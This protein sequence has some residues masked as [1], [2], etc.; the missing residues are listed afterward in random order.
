MTYLSRRI[1]L[2][3]KVVLITGASSGIGA[4]CAKYFAAEQANL[5]LCARRSDKLTA[6]ATELQQ[7]FNVKV[8][9]IA[10]DVRDKQQ[11]E[12]QFKALPEIW[13]QI[14]ILVNNAGLASGK[15]KLQEGHIEDWDRMIDTN[16][17]GLLYVT[18]QVLPKMV[19]RNAG[20]IIN[21]CSIS[22][23]DIYPGGAVYCASKFAIDAL[24]KGLRA[25]LLGKDIRVTAI[26]PGL[27]ETEFS[28]VR[29]HGDADR[30]NK[31]Y[32]GIQALTSEDVADAVIYSA[33]C[34][35]H[36]NIS[37]IILTPV[38][39]ATVLLTHRTQ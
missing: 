38:A 11:I 18:N 12:Q 10:L 21:M 39:Q 17:K 34:P 25:D 4:A 31:I 36:I 13:Q 30:A 5:I 32:Q 8:N 27:V 23:H 28:L 19:E 35:A 6:L 16:V 1:S 15:D 26:S 7:Q 29:Y 22:G 24:T 9:T 33:T 37:E 3:N 20:H 14:D 2:Q